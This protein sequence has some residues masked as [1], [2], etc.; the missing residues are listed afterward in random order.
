MLRPAREKF[1]ATY[2]E[3]WKA[4]LKTHSVAFEEATIAS[5]LELAE[6]LPIECATPQ[7]ACDSHQQMIGARKVINILCS[8]HQ[9]PPQP[10]PD[11]NKGLDYNAGV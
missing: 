6:D 3:A 5:L 9:P 11:R 7:T 1:L 10:K 4:A 2:G 8:L